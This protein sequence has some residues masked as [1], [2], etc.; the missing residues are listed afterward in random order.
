MADIA[1]VF[2]WQPSELK[3]MWLSE[4]LRWRERAAARAVVRRRGVPGGIR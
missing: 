2:H 3:A 4:L 1:C